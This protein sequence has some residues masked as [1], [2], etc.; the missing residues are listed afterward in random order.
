MH[1]KELG[2]R[3]LSVTTVGL[4]AVEFKFFAVS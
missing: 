3:T 1:R 4:W 2:K